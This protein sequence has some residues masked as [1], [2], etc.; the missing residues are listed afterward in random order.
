MDTTQLRELQLELLEILLDVQHFCEEQGITFYLGEGTLL[1]AVRHQGFIPW[2]DDIDI[3]MKPKDYEKFLNTA[4]EALQ[5][6]YVI[7]HPSTIHPCWTTFIKV[8][9]KNENPT[10]IQE[11]IRHLTPYCGPC[12]DIF[13]LEYVAAQDSLGQRLQCA[14]IR[15]CRRMIG[16]KLKI[17]HP[18]NLKTYL[19]K[20]LS[21]FF[22][23][24]WLHAQTEKAM[25]KQGNAEK[26][27]IAAFSTFHKY[28][29]VVAPKKAYGVEFTSFEG[30]KMPIPTG[31][32]MLLTKIYGDWR[33]IPKDA[34]RETKHHYIVVNEKTR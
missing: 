1:G 5:E 14:Q 30:Y 9:V 27:Y 31:Y 32:D 2:D 29:H 33:M 7:Q 18:F 22:S 25:H 20:L 4:P 8:R 10:F 34:Q 24:D 16:Y 28:R 19:I 6:K 23:V 13:P 26:D 17:W 12:I 3:L 15:L 21:C 11:H